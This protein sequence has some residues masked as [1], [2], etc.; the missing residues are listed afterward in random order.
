VR[1]RRRRLS[2]TTGICCKRLKRMQ[3]HKPEA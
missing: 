3:Q 2:V 1:Q